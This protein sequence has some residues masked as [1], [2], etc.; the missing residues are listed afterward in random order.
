MPQA[1]ELRA[2][3]ADLA[4]HELVVVH[5]LVGPERPAGRPPRD[6]QREAARAIQRHARLVDAA[7]P[8]D[9]AVANQLD[10]V[11]HFLRG[12]PVRRARL[13]ARTPP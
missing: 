10:R 3:L 7:Q 12:D 5:E 11:E 2:D 1:V 13:V 8:V 6:R 4:G 9:F